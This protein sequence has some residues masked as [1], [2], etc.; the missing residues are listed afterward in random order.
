[1]PK[2]LRNKYYE[3]LCVEKLM[4]A[5]KKARRGKGLR[6]EIIKF[7]LKQ[8]EYIYYLLEVLSNKT[9]KH[10]GY[11]V[12]YVTEPKLRKIEK[13]RYI[14][15][16]V[17]RWLVDNFLE[18]YFVPSFIN[19]SYACIKG[20]GMH[21]ACLDVQKAMRSCKKVWGNYYILKM[22]I[23]K[24]FENIDKRILLSI[25]EKKILDKDVMWLIK[26]I[27]YSQRKEVGLEIGNYTSQLFANI[28][29]NEADQ[30]VKKELGVKYYFRYMDD[31]VLM[32]SSKEEAKYCLE[33]IKNFLFLKLG[34]C[35]NKKTQIFKSK[36]GINFCGY[37]INENRLKLRDKGK[38]K[39]KK[40]V[41]KLKS[42]IKK[43]E[44]SSVE[45]KR[46]LSGHMGYIK[47]ADTWALENKL[48]YREDNKK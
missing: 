4:E 45:A 28:Y 41:K 1:M 34:L 19:T 37:K 16:V 22:D 23:S 42:L 36:Q 7:N 48:F 40:K 26:E 31:S 25:L 39:L 21:K 38:R 9:Y 20:R 44:I 13:S 29:L 43:G 30:Y 6:N 15:R 14:D 24:Y 35:L 12:F 47:I 10:G 2:T 46:F 3:N 18:P 27:L 33:K 17:H 11:E 8:E 5:H 32:V